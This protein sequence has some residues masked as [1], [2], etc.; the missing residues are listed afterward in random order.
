MGLMKRRTAAGLAVLAL[1]SAGGLAA[2]DPGGEAD[3]GSQAT[4]PA[5]NDKLSAYT[6]AFNTL[7]GGTPES[8]SGL[9]GFAESYLATDI[10]SASPEDTISLELNPPFLPRTLADLKKAREMRAGDDLAQ[11]DQAADRLIAAIDTIIR[12]EGTLQ[13]YYEGRVYRTDALARGKAADPELRKAYEDAMAA[14]TA[15]QN[16]LSAVQRRANDARIAELERDGH[17][18]EASLMTAMSRADAM[19]SAVLAGDGPAAD[20]AAGELQAA[21]DDMREKKSRLK[22]QSDGAMYDSVL[23][24][25][26]QALAQYRDVGID[27]PSAPDRIV[28]FYNNAVEFSGRMSVPS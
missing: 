4:S 23:N 24:M 18:A 21:L 27:D 26:T 19:T 22:S 17:V 10:A 9:T 11:V 28:P 13:G 8:Y 2:C 15:M 6:A 12:V 25:L 14:M 5:V 1:L 20:R 3:K 7:V 16:A